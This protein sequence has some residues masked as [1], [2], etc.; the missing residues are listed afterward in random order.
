MV[1]ALIGI[2]LFAMA[3]MAFFA[4]FP[5]S[6]Q[7]TSHD[8]EYLQAISAGQEYLDALRSAV[9]QSQPMPPPPTVPIDGGYSVTGNG[10]QNASPGNFQ[11]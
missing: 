2:T 11:I 1:E 7:T 8:D 6:L 3:L 9:E 5:Y 4:I 10:V